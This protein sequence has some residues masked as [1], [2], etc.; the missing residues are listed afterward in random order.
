MTNN[1]LTITELYIYPVKSL[2]GIRLKS[3]MVDERGLEHDRR[4]VLIDE[5][6]RFLTQRE[7]PEL[8]FFSTKII[9][10]QL[11]VLDRQNPGDPISLDLFPETG[12]KA[13]VQI[14]DDLCESIV[15]DDKVN[16]WFSSKLG[17]HARLAY[18]PSTTKRLVDGNYA[19][20]G[21]VTGFSDGYPILIIG[22]ASLADLNTRLET[23]VGMDRFRPN[24]VFSGGSAFEEDM[25]R[26]IE[27]NGVRMSGVKLCA[28]CV[29]TTT[30]QQTAQRSKE[31]LHTLATY[32][33]TNNKIYFGQN[34]LAK[35]SGSIKVGDPILYS[36]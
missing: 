3:S 11:V 1:N 13:I 30:D 36:T 26:D 22:E 33:K 18:M 4:W 20:E 6:N 24:L 32:R 15:L 19:S 21:E 29:M 7:L 10:Q 23:P 8:V 35:S 2:G 34:I 9:G 27:I 5:N 17:R 14:W 28:R 12:E 16:L 25:M 31:P